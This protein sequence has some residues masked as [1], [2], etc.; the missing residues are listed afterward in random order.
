MIYKFDY[1]INVV[2][3]AILAVVGASFIFIPADTLLNFIFSIIGLGI[4]LL[5]IVPCITYLNAV[6]SNKQFL[7]PA[8]TYS[9]TVLFGF[10]FIFGWTNVVISIMFGIVL[11]IL[12]I[13]RIVFNKGKMEVI[14]R[15]LPYIV[16]GIV[17]FFIPFSDILNVL[18]KIFGGLIILYSVYMIVL[19]LIKEKKNNKNNKN[20]DGN[21]IIIDAEIR[22]L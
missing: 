10:M 21:N 2:L 18:L 5:N 12:P 20:S 22:E 8:I 15:E 17:I 7:L 16:L 9:L 6:L 4:V 11:V 14:K 3:Y 13:I 19:L 1:K